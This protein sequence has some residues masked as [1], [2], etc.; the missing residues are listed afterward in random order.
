MLRVEVRE[1]RGLGDHEDKITCLSWSPDGKFIAVSG[2][3]FSV[4]VLDASD[5]GV[6][7]D[8]G[9]RYNE[10]LI[11]F[12]SPFGRHIAYVVPCEG[13]NGIG[14]LEVVFDY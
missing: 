11:L 3:D 7:F 9:P 14:L 6:L 10:D 8:T 1:L 5:G 4:R 2:A 12:W 13:C